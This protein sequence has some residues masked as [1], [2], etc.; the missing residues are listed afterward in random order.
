MHE[1]RE[2]MRNEV[3]S[4]PDAVLGRLANVQ[5][6]RAAKK[7]QREEAQAARKVKEQKKKMDAELRMLS[8]NCK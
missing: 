1:L 7:R 5:A 8:S 3:T 4:K 6:E 2:T